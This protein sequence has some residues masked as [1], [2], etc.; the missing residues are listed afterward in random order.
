[1]SKKKI[2]SVS[3][4]DL[5]GSAKPNP[6]LIISTSG[7]VPTLGW[8]EPELSAHIYVTPPQDGIYGFDFLA[9]PPTEIGGTQVAPISTSL[10][11]PWLKTMK[12]VRVYT[13]SNDI[14]VRLLTVDSPPA[15]HKDNFTIN[16]AQIVGDQIHVD[17]SYSGG[18]E[19]HDFELCWDGTYQ[20]SF[21]PQV[22]LNLVHNANG[23]PCDSIVNETLRFDLFQLAPSL[24]TLQNSFGYSQQ[25]PFGYSQEDAI[26]A[27]TNGFVLQGSTLPIL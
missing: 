24:I 22:T 27:S 6:K 25:I 15:T 20:T 1:M 10:Q 11:T 18:C 7:S 8:S 26:D 19:R 5:H 23:D 3:T 17:V 2:L 21:P 14:V 4:V 9:K 13:S 16:N 12:G